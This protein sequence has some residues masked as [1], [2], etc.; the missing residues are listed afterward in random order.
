MGLARVQTTGAVPGAATAMVPVLAATVEVVPVPVTTVEMGPALAM[1]AMGAV[2]ERV[3]VLG[4][5]GVVPEAEPEA[6]AALEPEAVTVLGMEVVAALA[7]VL[8]MG[9]GGLST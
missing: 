6:G 8:G 2:T 4:M 3:A 5:E 1:Q 9:M 7:T